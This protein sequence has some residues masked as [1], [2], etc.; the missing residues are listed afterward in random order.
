MFVCD[1]MT[2]S[3]WVGVNVYSLALSDLWLYIDLATSFKQHNFTQIMSEH[4]I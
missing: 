4:V 3:E 1:V 2:E